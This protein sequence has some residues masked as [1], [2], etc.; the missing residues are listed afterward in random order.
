MTWKM[1]IKLD[2]YKRY[3]RMKSCIDRELKSTTLLATM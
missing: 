2:A 3:L 1:Y